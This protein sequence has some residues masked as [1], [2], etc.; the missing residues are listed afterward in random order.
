[1]CCHSYLKL[2]AKYLL[3][4]S[5]SPSLHPSRRLYLTQLV[6][7]Q[8]KEVQIASEVGQSFVGK[9]TVFLLRPVKCSPVPPPHFPPPSSDLMFNFLAVI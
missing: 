1:M 6:S 5:C 9:L 8:G 7:F 4:L 2:L 3:C